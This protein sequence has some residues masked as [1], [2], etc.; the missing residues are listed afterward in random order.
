MIKNK[1]Y[2]FLLSLIGFSAL[3]NVSLPSFFSDNMVLQRN[4][5]VKLWGWG[6]PNEEIIITTG[7]DNATYTV[8]PDN[9]ANWQINIKTPKEGGPY[10]LK[11]KGYNEL[12][13]K[14][15]MLG[16]V[17][18]CS[19]QS[20]MEWTPSSGIDNAEE[21]ITKADYPN[22]RFFTVPKLTTQSPQI[23][24]PGSWQQCTPETMK[25][26]SAIA[27]FFAQHLQEDLKGVPIGMINS[28][29]GGTPAEIWMPQDYM[30]KDS[31]LASAAAKL[32]AS[33]WGPHKPGLAYNA[34]IH[35]FAGLK[36]AGVLW[37]QGE[38]NVGSGVYDK[39]L[40]GLITSWRAAWNDDFNFYYVQ[41]APFNYNEGITQGVSTR[42]E[43]RKV[44]Q[45]VPKTGMVV[46]SDVGNINDIHPRNK[47]PVGIRLANL[48]LSNQYGANQGLVN[49][50]LFKDLKVNK[51]KAT[52]NF[53]YAN[54]LHFKGKTSKLFE[55][56]GSDGVYHPAIAKIKNNA[57]IVYS[58]KV[59]KPKHVRF[60]WHNAALADV[61]NSANLPA[62]SFTSE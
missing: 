17:W 40:A 34:M 37:Y 57:V 13:F 27:Y 9:H 62:S 15:I 55:V 58:N 32:T 50:P 2:S 18:L 5:D 51:N 35:P 31:L 36:L 52:V 60:A 46:I 3:A 47:K 11:F 26:F 25:Y 1:I 48:A 44:L 24:L 22:I 43:Q 12:V 59:E 29:W 38:S 7:W 56:A 30:A 20:N 6:S 14:N 19:G 41:I 54:G 4:S 23:N 53:N 21:E 42:N 39:T 8:K 45:L 61:F 28:S 49:S 16:E 10:T 33:E